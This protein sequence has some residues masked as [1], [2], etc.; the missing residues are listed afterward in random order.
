MKPVEEVL[1]EALAAIEG[2]HHRPSMYVGSTTQPGAAN[3]LDGMLW[4][5]HWFWATVQDRRGELRGHALPSEAYSRA[6]LP[7]RH[8]MPRLP[9]SS[10]T[11]PRYCIAVIPNTTGRTVD[12]KE[13]ISRARMVT[14]G[15]GLS[16]SKTSTRARAPLRV[17]P[18]QPVRA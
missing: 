14:S 16:H 7:R 17:L 9:D 5:A 12:C 10:C 6:A 11:G 8:M 13:M 18:R 15:R 2:L 3:T 1:A 4:I